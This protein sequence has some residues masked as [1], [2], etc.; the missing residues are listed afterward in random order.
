VVMS[1]QTLDQAYTVASE[2]YS[3][4]PQPLSPAEL[5]AAPATPTLPEGWTVQS[6]YRAQLTITLRARELPE[7]ATTTPILFLLL[8]QGRRTVEVRIAETRDMVARRWADLL[9]AEGEPAPVPLG[10]GFANGPSG[11]IDTGDRLI[12][13]TYDD[14]TDVRGWSRDQALSRMLRLEDRVSRLL[15]DFH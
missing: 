12:H 2:E 11:V 5:L 7:R 13:V 1:A 3:P 14:D 4:A 9:M 10:M 15:L 6:G 8:K